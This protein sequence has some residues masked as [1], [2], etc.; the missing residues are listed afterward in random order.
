M[1]Q[2]KEP[3]SDPHKYS[4]LIF[5]KGTKAMPQTEDSLLKSIAKKLDVHIQKNEPRQRPYTYTKRN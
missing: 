5:N 3:K 1:E 4:Q 2:N